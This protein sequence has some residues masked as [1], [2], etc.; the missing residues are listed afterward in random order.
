MKA[1][2]SWINAI[3]NAV[4]KRYHRQ[5]AAWY[6]KAAATHADI[7]IHTQYRVPTETLRML[8]GKAQMHSQAAIAIRAGE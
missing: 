3:T 4:L 6:Q 5:M 1:A 2:T 8:R 7:V